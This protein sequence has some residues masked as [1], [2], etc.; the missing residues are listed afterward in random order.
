MSALTKFILWLL[1]MAAAHFAILWAVWFVDPSLWGVW[2]WA[3]IGR[4]TYLFVMVGWAIIV[5]CAIADED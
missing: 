1:F 5:A 2:S 3:G 4:A